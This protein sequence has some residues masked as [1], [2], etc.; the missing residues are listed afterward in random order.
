MATIQELQAKVEEAQA[1][2]EKAEKLL[3]KYK[4]QKA[5]KVLEVNKIL[6]QNNIQ[7][8]YEDI[9][10][11]Y[12][13]A[14]KYYGTPFHHD[15]YW[16][17]C[18]V[19]DKDSGIRSAQRK[20]E[21]AKE[22]LKKAKER[23]GA[24]E[25]KIQ[26]IQD[27]VPEVLKIFLNDWKKRVIEYYNKKVEEY[28][29]AYKQYKADLHRTYYEVL[30]ETVDRL[31]AEDK[32]KFI[33][34]YCWNKESRFHEVMEMLETYNPEGPSSYYTSYSSVLDFNYR[35]PND[36]YHNRRYESV[37]DV[38][39]MR[40]GDG[41]FQSWKDRKF[42]KDWL[43]QEIEQEKNNKLI[44]LMT[45]VTKITGTITDAKGLYIEN[46]DINGVIVGERG[47]AKVQ[48]IGAG[49]YNEHV[50]LD[51]GRRGQRFHFRVLVM[52]RK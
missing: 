18:D 45:R 13:L 15:F 50:I 43:E 49:G 48:T 24:E 10:N 30:K 11:E 47:Q 14:H 28:P 8:K 35:D 4:T 26:Y 52:P 44:D 5:K 41:F 1:K 31:V 51:S 12:N 19:S 34:D 32:E 40:F 22:R 16:A 9:E 20:I 42:D 2:V 46:G 23:L 39:N 21:E 27:S 33:K 7:V 25:A 29:E 37:K 6:E 3:E 38:F 17:I 36:P